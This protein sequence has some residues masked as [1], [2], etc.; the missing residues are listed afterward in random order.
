M[1]EESASAIK[2]VTQADG[3]I[4]LQRSLDKRKMTGAGREHV[5]CPFRRRH[6]AIRNI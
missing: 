1:N 5:E 2:L 4:S 6:I 3:R